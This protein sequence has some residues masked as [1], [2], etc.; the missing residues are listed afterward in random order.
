MTVIDLKLFAIIYNWAEYY[1]KDGRSYTPSNK[2]LSN[3]LGV[4]YDTVKKG[5]ETL[6]ELKLIHIKQD[7]NGFRTLSTAV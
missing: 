2:A 7:E 6:K 5:L 3:Q 4:D 1:A